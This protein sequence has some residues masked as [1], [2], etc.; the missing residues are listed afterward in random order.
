MLPARLKPGE[1]KKLSPAMQSMLKDFTDKQTP[2]GAAF[3][4][5]SL[6]PGYMNSEKFRAAQLPAMN[7]HGTARDVA[8]LMAEVPNLLSEILFQKAVATVSRG[9]DRVLKARTHFG[10]GYMLY[11]EESPIGWPGCFGHA[12]A[13]GSVAFCDPQ[14]KL[15]FAFVMNQM[16]QGVVSGGTTATACVQALQECLG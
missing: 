16:E 6:G 1:Q 8:R 14:K 9:P 2:T 11:E 5:P 4:N 7:G 13:G 12:G 15:G 10:L 3:Q